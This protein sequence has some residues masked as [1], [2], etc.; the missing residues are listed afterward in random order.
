MRVRAWLPRKHAG[1][2]IRA[3]RELCST[4]TANIRKRRGKKVPIYVP[5]Y[6]DERTDMS[7]MMPANPMTAE[8]GRA[9]AKSVLEARAGGT[10]ADAPPIT[11]A[12]HFAAEATLHYIEDGTWEADNSV[13]EACVA[14]PGQV[15]MDCM[16]YG[17]GC[18]CLQVTFQARDLAESRYLYDT[19]GVLSPLMV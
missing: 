17:M 13:G 14:Q 2:S 12:V 18:C 16:A 4:L 19:L 3:A 15:H 5:L 7:G 9:W 6:R 10:A 8:S 11:E 1:L